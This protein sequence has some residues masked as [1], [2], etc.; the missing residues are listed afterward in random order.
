MAL[1]S[2]THHL[3]TLGEQQPTPPDHALP[4]TMAQHLLMHSPG[5]GTQS[6]PPTAQAM[7]QMAQQSSHSSLDLF[8]SAV[9]SPTSSLTGVPP[10]SHP[11]PPS[12]ATQVCAS[13]YAL[14]RVFECVC[15]SPVV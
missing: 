6:S 3:C 15:F 14:V 10:L 8:D 13:V 2:P 4:H 11:P 12:P 7:H 9:T 5:Y 1:P